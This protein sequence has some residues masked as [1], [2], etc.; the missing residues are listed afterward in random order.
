MLEVIHVN[1][2]E[3]WK[4]AIQAGQEQFMALDEEADDGAA[5][6]P[7]VFYHLGI[8]LGA[9]SQV[10]PEDNNL[11]WV[12]NP[13]KTFSEEIMDILTDLP[14][15]KGVRPLIT[16]LRNLDRGRI[17]DPTAMRSVDEPVLVS[18]FDMTEEGDDE[19]EV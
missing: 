2:R 7:I 12:H 6:E 3:Y 15:Y 17:P 14:T 11:F 5:Y 8:A 10:K 4:R 18:W 16:L 1:I 13:G 19:R 9:A